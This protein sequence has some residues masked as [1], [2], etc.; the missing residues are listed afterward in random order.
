MVCGNKLIGIVLIIF[1]AGI[2]IGGL[3]PMLAASLIGI[4]L[5][6]VGYLILC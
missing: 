2:F 1:G 3:I 6:V 4:L 5:C